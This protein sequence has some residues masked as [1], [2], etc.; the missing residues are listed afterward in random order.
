MDFDV[1]IT[2]L[3]K[4][5]LFANVVDQDGQA[6]TSMP[7]GG[8][9][10]FESS[11]VAVVNPVPLPGGLSAELGS[12]KVGTAVITVTPGGSLTGEAFAAREGQIT[13]VNSEPTAFSL[14]LGDEQDEAT[15]PPIE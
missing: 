4:R 12:G 14:T 1:Q 2:N 13:V 15:P 7:P 11:D 3:K 9:M 10:T 8:T 5:T 6:Y